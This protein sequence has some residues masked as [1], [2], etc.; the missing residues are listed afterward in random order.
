M[1]DAHFGMPH[2]TLFCL[3]Y[4]EEKAGD[5]KSIEFRGGFLRDE[6]D[7]LTGAACS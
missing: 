7:S 3:Y 6:P 1:K 5:G 4:M 2:F